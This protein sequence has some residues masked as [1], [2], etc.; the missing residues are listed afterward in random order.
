MKRKPP[1]ELGTHPTMMLVRDILKRYPDPALFPQIVDTLG[2]APD[3]ARL[4]NAHIEWV[5]R[6]YNPSNLAW[7][8]DWYV[9]NSTPRR[10]PS[11]TNIGKPSTPAPVGSEHK[12]SDP[13]MSRLL[14]QI[15]PPGVSFAD[16]LTRLIENEQITASERE[17][18]LTHASKG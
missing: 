6:G 4:R 10:Q 5:K 3:E 12:L 8:F 14:E 1:T 18:Y 13:D 15:C 17:V 2:D 16:Y 7:L 9:N 11:G